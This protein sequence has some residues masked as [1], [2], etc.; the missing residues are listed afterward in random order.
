MPPSDMGRASSIVNANDEDHRRMRKLQ[1]HAFSDRALLGQEPILVKYVD[2]LMRRIWD[3]VNDKKVDGIVDLVRWY[4]FT[5]FDLIGDL[6]FGRSFGCLDSGE[7]HFWISMVFGTLKI[8]NYLQSMRFISTR[9]VKLLFAM[10]PAKMK[11]GRGKQFAFAKEMAA[12]R[13]SEGVDRGDGRSDFMSYI[14]RANDEKGMTTKEIE[15]ASNIY[16]IAGSETTATL[17][18][19]ATYHLLKNPEVMRKLVRE[20][21]RTFAKEAD[22]QLAPLAQLSYLNAVFEEAL[23]MFPPVPSTMPRIVPW[24]GEFVLDEF[25]PAGTVVGVN[26]WATNYSSENF[27]RPGE[28]IPERWLGKK[29]FENDDRKAA[30]PFSFGP[31]NCIGKNLAYN[32]MRLILSRVL[33]SFDLELQ[34]ES[35]G[36]AERQIVFILWEKGPLK[37]KLTPKAKA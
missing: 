8:G 6:A 9:F 15:E 7:M 23:R 14:L 24:P 21:R 11:E 19:G 22:I 1:S 2:L 17:L 31:R 10:I 26:Q 5:T 32:E 36:W 13:I 18:S 16:I 37:V 27:T 4:N 12:Q 28:F 25:L 29:E 33:W 20:V 30:Q 3:Q 35:Q 34:D